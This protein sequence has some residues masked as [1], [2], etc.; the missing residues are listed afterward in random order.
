VNDTGA[1][2]L[3][4][5]ESQIAF[6]E[7]QYDELNHVVI[8]QSRQLARIQAELGRATQALSGQELERIRANNQKPPHYE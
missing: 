1:E 3:Q 5:I 8:E 6:L 4:K 2:R 7:R